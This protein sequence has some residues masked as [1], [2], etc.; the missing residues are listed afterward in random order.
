M[1]EIALTRCQRCA[2]Y[3]RK[4][5]DDRVDRDFNSIESQ[6]DICAAYVTCQKHKGWTRVQ[7]SYDDPGQ[8]GA[9]INRPALQRL[10]RDIEA[11]QIDVVII[12][13]IDRLTRSLADFIRLIGSKV[14]VG[15]FGP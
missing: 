9:T 6:L 15:A 11:G 7:Q 2:I 1:S 8:S 13:K 3:T 5:T 14:Q 10:L 12:Y 4:S